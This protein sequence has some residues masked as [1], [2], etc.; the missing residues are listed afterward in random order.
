MMHER[1]GGNGASRRGRN[2]RAGHKDRT[3]EASDQVRRSAQPV[4]RWLRRGRRRFE[5]NVTAICSRRGGSAQVAG[6]NHKSAVAKRGA[7][8]EAPAAERGPP[9]AKDDYPHSAAADP[10][11]PGVAVRGF[12]GFEIR[13][14]APAQAVRLNRSGG[15]DYKG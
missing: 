7:A 11:R 12:H 15:G 13:L 3:G 2:Q 5:K 14:L 10:L 9:S 4:I 1:R 8:C 6:S